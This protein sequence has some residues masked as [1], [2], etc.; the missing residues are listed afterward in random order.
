MNSKK[1][2]NNLNY[3]LT[4]TLILETLL[5]SFFSAGRSIVFKTLAVVF[6]GII[7]SAY[8]STVAIVDSGTDYKHEGLIN[9]IWINQAETPNND[10]DED[11]NGYQDDVYGWNFAESNNEV[12]DYSYLG[13]LNDDIKKFF[14]IQAK[15]MTG[16]ATEEEMNW[17]R[18]RVSD[19]EFL[20]KLQIYGNFMHGTHVAGIA[21]NDSSDIKL[22]S[23]KLIPTEVKLPAEDESGSSPDFTSDEQKPAVLDGLKDKLI[24]KALE[25]LAKQQMKLLTE[26]SEYVGKHKS[27][28]A[29]GSFG[30]GYAQ[31]K[32][33]IS[34]VAEGLNLKLTEQEIKKY[35]IHFINE[36]VKNGEDMVS[37]SPKTLWVFAA[38]NDGTNND[39]LPSSPTNIQ[40]DNVI[41]VAATI[42]FDIIAPFSNYGIKEVDVAAP[43]VSIYSTVPGDEYL[44]VS[45]TSQAAPYVANI[46]GK[47]KDMNPKLTP[48]E[49]KKIIMDSVDK[50]DDLASL[51]KAGGIVNKERAIKA[52]ELSLTMSLEEA[53]TK[54]KLEV[55][56]QVRGRL[57]EKGLN[58]TNL[59]VLPLPSPFSL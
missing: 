6:L 38:G 13:I 10:R 54:S 2:H 25:A 47:I 51:V 22:L 17:L 1:K 40:A 44:S 28:V 19:S 11:R 16:E 29:N 39:E 35:A 14:L 55:E 7:P 53:I 4:I 15:A 50:R 8:S 30:T 42:G 58:I 37:E 31:A 57:V 59:G 18:D 23:V 32:M 24:K 52:A 49:M 48:K 9:N 43:G 26:I 27:D 20:K 46:A 5:S 34:A 33:L 56:D 45:G 21:A 3:L 41:S 36:L 12:I